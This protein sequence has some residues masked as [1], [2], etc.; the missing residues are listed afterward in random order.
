MIR[1]VS[2]LFIVLM[3]FQFC[4]TAQSTF[5]TTKNKKAIKF[6]H[7]ALTCFNTIDHVS[8]KAD[9]TGAEENIK[10]ALS[11][12]SLFGEAYGLA[13][14]ISIEKGKIQEAI[15]SSMKAAKGKLV[16]RPQCFE[17]YG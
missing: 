16:Q 9:L 5:Y 10:K 12:D 17:L 11:K 6:Y 3:T 8:G 4:S 14:K 1:I 7:K 13:S 15:V 2:V